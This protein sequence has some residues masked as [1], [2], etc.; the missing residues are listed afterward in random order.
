[1]N[2]VRIKAYDHPI[3]N[4]LAFYIETPMIEELRTVIARWLWNGHTGGYIVG[5]ARVGKSRAIR[6]AVE[7]LTTRGGQPIPSFYMDFHQRDRATIASVFRNLK[8]ALNLKLRIR[9][10]ADEMSDDILHCFADAAF[11]NAHRYVILVV[12]EVQRATTQ[13]LLAFTELYDILIRLQTNLFVL[14]IANVGESDALLK[15]IADNKHEQIRGRFFING[16][17]YHGLRS[18]QDLEACLRQYDE[19]RCPADGPTVTEV[20]LPS[21][22]AQGWRLHKLAVP[23]WQMYREEFQQPLHLES[24]G[25]Q[26]FTAA[27]KTLLVDYLPAFGVTNAAEVEVMIRKSIQASGLERSSVTVASDH[28]KRKPLCT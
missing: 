7:N 15:E 2:T 28:R 24:W 5:H 23:I 16:H 21:Q 8:R 11:G 9:E 14:F 13:Q 17:S 19:L 27:I 3:F 1:M 4:P 18:Y 20:F 22:Y 10:V 25:M 12:D 6:K 26:Y